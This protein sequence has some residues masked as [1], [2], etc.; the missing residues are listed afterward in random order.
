MLQHSFA[1]LVAWE[2]M[3]LSSMLL[4]IFDGHKPKTLKAGLN[5]LVQ[6][7]IS[8]ILLTIGFI[9]VYATTGSFSFD[10]FST[11][12]ANNNNTWLF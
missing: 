4:V 8:V 11:F 9:W 7:H 10:A 3:S 6:M 12:F 1:F 5:Y 2:I